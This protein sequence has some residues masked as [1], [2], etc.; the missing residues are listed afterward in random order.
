MWPFDSAKKP[1]E[2]ALLYPTYGAFLGAW[3]GVIPIGLDWDRPWQVTTMHAF[4][5]LAGQL[6]Y[7]AGISSHTSSWCIVGL[8]DWCPAR[9]GHEPAAIFC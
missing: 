3:V 5:M 7:I 4:Y 6:P 9:T 8:H 2:R 1:Y